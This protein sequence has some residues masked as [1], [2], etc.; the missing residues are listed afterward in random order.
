MRQPACR[1]AATAADTS[2]STCCGA[3]Q[4]TP[5]A[6]HGSCP[7]VRPNTRPTG[8]PARV[9]SSSAQVSDSQAGTARPS[10]DRTSS[11]TVTSCSDGTV[12]IASRSAPAASQHL[13]PL[14]VEVRRYAVGHSVVAV[15]L[16]AVGQNRA[17]RPDRGGD[18]PRDAVLGLCLRRGLARKRTLSPQQRRRALPRTCREPQSRRRTPGSSRSWRPGAGPEERQVGRHDLGRV[19]D[20]AAA[21][22]RGRRTGRGRAARARW[23]SRRRAADGEAPSRR[24]TSPVHPLFHALRRSMTTAAELFTQHEQTLQRA[25]TAIRERSYWSAYPENLKAYGNRRLPTGRSPPPRAR[26][27]SRPTWARRSR[28]TRAAPTAGVA[29]ERSPYGIDLG[30][31]YPHAGHR[32]AARRRDRR[33]SRPGATPART[34]APVS[35]SRSCPHQ[36]AQPRD[37]AGRDAHD[38]PG[39]RDGVP[40]R[41]TARA[42]PRARGD[43]LLPTPR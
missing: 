14:G 15:V 29:G 23:R 33:R 35:R 38:R 3:V 10:A 18:Q 25:L 42:G 37:G 12:S 5:T 39:V 34:P 32:R 22:T 41:R 11:N 13:E 30:M 36:R 4:L 7:R 20:A 1:Y 26:R 9:V 19:V 17:V 16:R 40:G 2:A 31:S 28:S 8:S 27:P 6:R 43:R 21:R 24:T